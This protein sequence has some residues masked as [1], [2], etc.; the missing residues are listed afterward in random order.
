MGLTEIK[1]IKFTDKQEKQLRDLG[2]MHLQALRMLLQF[3]DPTT[4]SILV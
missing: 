1:D 4:I 2:M 3:L